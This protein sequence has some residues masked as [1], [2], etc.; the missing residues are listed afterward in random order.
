MSKPRSSGDH[1]HDCR[2]EEF[3]RGLREQ[4][5]TGTF[6]DVVLKGSEESAAGIPCHRNVLGVHSAYFRAV[7]TQDWKDSAEPAFQLRNI[8]SHTLNEL[9]KYAYTLDL[10]LDGDNVQCILE[11]AEF[12]QMAAVASLCWEYVEDHL[13]LSDCLD[14]HALASNHHNSHM[15]EA[16][17][18]L[19]RRHFLHF[20]Q[21]PDFLQMDAQQLIALIAADDV[22]VTSEDQ[23]LQAVQRWLDHDR[24]ER[25]AHLHAVLQVVRVPFLSEQGRQEYELT[26]ASAPAGLPERSSELGSELTKGTETTRTTNP[27]HSCGA[28]DAILCVGGCGM[29]YDGAAEASVDVFC[30]AIPAVWRLDDLPVQVE[31]CGVVA[32]D[33]SSMMIC[34]SRAIMT[35]HRDRRYTDLDDQ[36]WDEPRLRTPRSAAGFAALNGRVYAVGGYDTR[37]KIAG[38]S[39]LLSSVEAYD[40]DSHSWSAVAALPVA[41]AS[42]ALVA[43]DGRLY[44]FGG[45]GEDRCGCSLA[46]SYDPATDA[47]SRLADM[48]TAR[49]GAAACVAP[50]G[51]IYAVGGN[52]ERHVEAYDRATNQWLKKGETV[53]ARYEFGCAI[54]SGKLYALGG[55]G[56]P[57]CHDSIEVYDEDADRWALHESRLPQAKSHFGCAVMKLKRGPR[58]A[59]IK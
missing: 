21:R 17:L 9:V 29:A 57:S 11:A 37:D 18:G 40:L 56:G 34:G 45:N 22:D 59:P 13:Q 1:P 8:D 14:I 33:A 7:F 16:S 35:V 39:I 26:L 5:S 19:I 53:R 48:P 54:A 36:W 44:A 2:A 49:S 4:Q 51:L 23:V 55:Y 15:I 20:T 10:S 52:S 25:L 3:L 6:C 43:C 50:S 46:F 12:L 31:Q 24:P 27:R 42:V 58:S 47:W 32:L 38:R 30:P 41:L 28:Q